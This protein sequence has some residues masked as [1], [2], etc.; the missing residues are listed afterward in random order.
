MQKSLIGFDGRNGAITFVIMG[1]DKSRRER[2]KAFSIQGQ[3]ELSAGHILEMAI[4]LS[5]APFLAQ[6]FGDMLSAFIPMP[7]NSGLD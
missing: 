2:E 1:A 5:P 4:W 3:Q 7:V 6:D